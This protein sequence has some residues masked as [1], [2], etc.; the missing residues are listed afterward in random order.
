MERR[1]FLKIGSAG[2]AGALV[3]GSGLITWSKRAHAATINK[4]FYI[5]D[6]TLVQPDGVGVYFRGFSDAANG[7]N[8]PGAA[9]IVQ[10]GDT[11]NI[12]VVNTL[13]TT[14]SF[15]IDGVVDS[16]PI[17]G[18]TQAVVSFSAETPGTYAYYDSQ[19]PP[20][21]R[22]LGLHGGLAVM[23]SGSTN[24]LYAGSPTFVKQYFWVFNDIDPVWHNALA[25]GANPTTPFFP[26]YFTINGL[27]SR[28]PGAPG[29]GDPSVDAN[30]DPR[31]LLVGSIGDRSLVRM[32][33][34][35]LCTH[36][37]HV[38]ANHMEWLTLNGAIRSD[39]WKKDIL[40]LYGNMGRVD[41]IYPF[42]AP[43]DAYPPVTTG[44]Y[45]MHLHDEM[46]QT[47]GGGLYLFGTMTEI[48]FV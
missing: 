7:L 21:N 10:Q 46:T 12:T 34:M 6:G 38:H 45:P 8:V 24:T 25:G 11:V 9:L 36:S 16:G 5:T 47:A 35:S 29:N 32:I 3:A 39:I 14:H 42:E 1:K 26:R 4:T 17:A 13:S 22:L 15:V 18:G 33:N 2:I 23:P 31:S 48:H 27:S 37:M 20:Y 41:A 44:N 30:A 19:N 40:P 43:P 28:P